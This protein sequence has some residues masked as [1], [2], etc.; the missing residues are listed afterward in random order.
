MHLFLQAAVSQINIAIR[1]P[2]VWKL[3]SLSCLKE[4]GGIITVTR[5]IDYKNYF[6]FLLPF[7]CSEPRWYAR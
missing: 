1:L 4:N 7:H 3:D 2:V 6:Y 5:I